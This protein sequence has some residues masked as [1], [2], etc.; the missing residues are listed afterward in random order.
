MISLYWLEILL[1]FSNIFHYNNIPGKVILY[2]IFIP[3]IFSVIFC[4]LYTI[5]ETIKFQNAILAVIRSNKF[6]NET[7]EYFDNAEKI[8]N[9]YFKKMHYKGCFYYIVGSFLVSYTLVN[10]LP[11]QIDNRK[12]FICFVTII[13][14]LFGLLWNIYG[15]YSDCRIDCSTIFIRLKDFRINQ[16][17]DLRQKKFWAYKMSLIMQ[18]VIIIFFV[19]LMTFILLTLKED[20]FNDN[21][22]GYAEN[23]KDLILYSPIIALLTAAMTL[24]L[25]FTINYFFDV[26]EKDNQTRNVFCDTFSIT[27]T[28]KNINK[29]Y[30]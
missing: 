15:Y 22:D 3:I 6:T 12:L 21:L 20:I 29:G 4:S 8:L 27:R 28:N 16:Y 23:L 14:F 2:M 1:I 5:S 18:L 11:L 13:G 30:K 26:T 17:D 19:A 24:Y 9:S 7:R 25:K 10:I